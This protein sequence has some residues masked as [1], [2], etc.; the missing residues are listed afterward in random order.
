MASE[1]SVKVGEIRKHS[2]AQDAWLVIDG[3]VWDFTQFAPEH[4][5]GPQ[6]TKN[7]L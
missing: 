2:T 7:Q 1:R 6:S 4:P 3:V 5:G